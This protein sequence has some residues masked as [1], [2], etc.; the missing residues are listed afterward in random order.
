MLARTNPHLL[1]G[2]KPR[3]FFQYFLPDGKS[4]TCPRFRNF[5]ASASAPPPLLVLSTAETVRLLTAFQ[6]WEPAA[7][8]KF[9][10]KEIFIWRKGSR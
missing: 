10:R 1:T 2:A 4:E 3:I 8:Q 5:S 9:S 7:N 6:L